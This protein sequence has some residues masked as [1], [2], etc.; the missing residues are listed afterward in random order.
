MKQGQYPPHP[1]SSLQGHLPAAL[2]PVGTAGITG[3]AAVPA[4]LSLGVL[5]VRSAQVPV[6]WIFSAR[7]PLH[8]PGGDKALTPLWCRK[9]PGSLP[10][11]GRAAPVHP[12][13]LLA[14]RLPG[15]T[16]GAEGTIPTG[17]LSAMQ[18]HLTLDRHDPF[19][20]L[21]HSALKKQER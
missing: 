1:Q 2:S 18:C 14:V 19:K 20:F 6:P 3:G 8:C 21:D 16:L 7:S 17:C 12:G 4:A 9:W 10:G 5:L 15:P 11:G 13:T